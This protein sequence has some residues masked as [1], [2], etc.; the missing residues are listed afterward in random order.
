MSN[1]RCRNGHTRTEQNTVMRNGIRTCMDCQRDSNRKSKVKPTR[2]VGKR[3]RSTQSVP[4]GS[5]LSTTA[6]VNLVIFEHL[7]VS[8]AARQASAAKAV[9]AN[10]AW[11]RAKR[12]VRSRDQERCHKCGRRNSN[13]D[14]HHRKPKQ[15]GGADAKTT[16][17]LANLVSLCRDCHSWVHQHP[18][19]AM[20]VGLLLSQSAEPDREYIT[21]RGQRVALTYLGMIGREGMVNGSQDHD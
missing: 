7:K 13:L 10:A 19:E 12:I 9:V 5:K 16:Y 8:T 1:R 20:S 11:E 15:M 17:G 3:P 18:E 21:S 4:G 6:A 14:V 2:R